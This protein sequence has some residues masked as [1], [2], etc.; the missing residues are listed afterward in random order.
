[1]YSLDP[2]THTCCGLCTQG[3][4]ETMN[5]KLGLLV[6]LPLVSF[7]LVPVATAATRV[8]PGVTSVEVYGFVACYSDGGYGQKSGASLTYAGYTIDVLCTQ[9]N[10]HEAYLP[11]IFVTGNPK[12][13]ATVFAQGHHYTVSA[14]FGIND[15]DSSVYGKQESNYAEGVFDISA[16]F[17]PEL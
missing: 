1:M 4:S 6:L 9:G 12:F 5:K 2:V 16:C 8:T 7:M 11:P 17:V 15:C 13:T 14:H 3:V 10:D